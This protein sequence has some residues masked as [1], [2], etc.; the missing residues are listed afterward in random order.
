MKARI[1]VYNADGSV[2]YETMESGLVD[3]PRRDGVLICCT[4]SEPANS[5]TV[6]T[7][8]KRYPTLLIE[9]DRDKRIGRY[10]T[11]PLGGRIEISAV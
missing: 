5:G 1:T 10:M 3:G 9:W 7:V 6:D 8:R 4:E 2:L 11:P